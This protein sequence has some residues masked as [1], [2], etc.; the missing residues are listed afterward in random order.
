MRHLDSLVEFAAE[1]AISFGPPAQAGA[2]QALGGFSQG[3][4]QDTAT[5]PAQ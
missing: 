3:P 5:H 4:W 2:R 1:Q